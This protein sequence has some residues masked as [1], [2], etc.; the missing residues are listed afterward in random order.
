VVGIDDRAAARAIARLAFSGA[1]APAILSFPLDRARRAQVLTGPD[2]QIAAFPVTR[3]RLTGFKDAWEETGGSWSQVQVAVCAV[4]SARLG[5]EAT[6]RLLDNDAGP[7]ALAAM[8]DELALGALH[9]AEEFGVAVPGVL[10]VTGWDDTDAAA[11]AGLSTLRQDLRDHG[12][13]CARI[14]LGQLGTGTPP[15][16]E[17]RRRRSTRPSASFDQ[18]ADTSPEPDR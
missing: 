16:W 11:P 7:D 5:A 15:R 9:T 4:N 14:A 13:R 12:A 18:P 17:V 8:S 3:N 10:A 2:P 1:R 6:A